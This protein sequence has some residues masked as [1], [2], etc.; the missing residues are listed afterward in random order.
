MRRKKGAGLMSLRLFEEKRVYY[1]S[2]TSI[3][4]TGVGNVTPKFV[5]ITVC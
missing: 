1:V 4:G 2:V 3:V 5:G